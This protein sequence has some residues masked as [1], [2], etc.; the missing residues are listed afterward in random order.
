[1]NL[2]I[3]ETNK[4][5]KLKAY[6]RMP[7][8]STA[9]DF[10]N[11]LN[12]MN[13][14][15]DIPCDVYHFDA[16]VMLSGQ[17]EFNKRFDGTGILGPNFGVALEPSAFGAKILYSDKNPPW[18][19]EMCRD[20]DAIEDFVTGLKVPH[21]MLD[22]QLPLFYQ[23]FNYM[24]HLADGALGAPSGVIAS[25]DVASL[26]ISMENLSMLIKLNPDLAHRLIETVNSFLIDFIE[27][28]CEYFDVDNLVIVDLY[29]D[30]A[31]Y[32]SAD[33]FREFVLPYNKK[34][35]DYFGGKDTINLWHCDGTLG[36]LMDLI[37]EMGCNCLYSFD[38]H[39]PL[40]TFVDRIGDRVC[41][42]GNLDPI[43]LVRNGTPDEVY[44][45]CLEQLEIGKRAAGFVL[46]TGGELT[47]GTP[48]A[49]ID[50]ILRAVKDHNVLHCL[51]RGIQ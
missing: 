19:I 5:L 25:F 7:T 49:N 21:P 18:V 2:Y 10:S 28:K 50:A 29:G 48:E 36:H 51:P 41:L 27:A 17:A 3:N 37:P 22:G 15:R 4:S 31:G 35:Y 13:G 45:G 46:S 47:H 40:S 38:P 8:E 44:A 26:L 34:I 9:V 42:V 30:N 43:R 14:W 23:T 16:K 32:I 39:T 1:M 24:Q 33:D 12:F 20:Y 6:K 11:Q